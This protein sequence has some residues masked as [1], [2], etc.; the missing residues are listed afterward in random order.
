MICSIHCG[1]VILSRCNRCDAQNGNISAENRACRSTKH[2]QGI[3][4]PDR[5]FEQQRCLAK[6][7][8]APNAFKKLDC[9]QNQNRSEEQ[10]VQ[11]LQNTVGTWR[12]QRGENINGRMATRELKKRQKSKD[13]KVGT[14]LDQ[15]EIAIDRSDAD[16]NSPSRQIG[17]EGDN[18]IGM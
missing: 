10:I 17:H 13:R 2:A 9:D 8:L 4:Q 3:A 7:Q 5:K 6:A 12:K 15:L 1:Q 16:I 11:H 14:R 18:K